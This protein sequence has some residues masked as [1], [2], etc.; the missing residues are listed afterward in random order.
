MIAGAS[1][2]SATVQLLVDSVPVDEGTICAEFSPACAN[3]QM[4][5]NTPVSI[6]PL[7]T[8]MVVFSD[9]GNV[10][11]NTCAQTSQNGQI[12]RIEYQL[13]AGGSSAGPAFI[14][15]YFGTN[16]ANL[17]TNTCGNPPATASDCG[18]YS[19]SAGVFT[20]LLSTT[21]CSATPNNSCGFSVN[22]DQW[23]SC[24]NSVIYTFSSP[25]YVI[26]WNNITV[27]GST[28]LA[29]GTRVP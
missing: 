24:A 7:P 5:A 17:T 18:V 13:M 21:Y 26:D 4:G 14:K 16:G 20:D 15:E 8:S 12:R 19:N 11:T 28:K 27:N 10:Q 25:V 3:A 6:G 22:P 2:G 29:S 9:P 1:Q 23:Q